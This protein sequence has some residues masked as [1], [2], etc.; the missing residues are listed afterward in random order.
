MDPRDL[1]KPLP[2]ILVILFVAV[3]V[4]DLVQT[5]TENPPPPEVAESVVPRFNPEE[6]IIDFRATDGPAAVQILPIPEFEPERWSVATPR[7]VWAK[8]RT[9]G[10]TIDLAAGGHRSMVLECL[11]GGGKHPVRSVRLKVNQVDCGE[12]ML[13]PGLGSY[14]IVLPEGAFRFGPNR[15]VFS[16][17]DR[18]GSRKNRRALLI[19]RLALFSD[20]DSGV[21][22]L[23]KFR[24]ISLG[25]EAEKIALRVAGTLEV[26][27]NLDD[28]SDALR[29]RY[30]FSSDLGRAEVAV[31]QL[32]S[33][34]V[35]VR[36]A[37]KTT[38]SADRELTGH[39]RISLHGRR[40]PYVLRLRA[41]P[42][43]RGSR[44]V[45]SSLRLTEEGDPTGR[46]W[47]ANPLRN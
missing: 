39:L 7:G 6:P 10:L 4:A 29:M 21:E 8:G 15:V 31:V 2:L 13:N 46:P 24:P 9:A 26:P 23:G 22:N 5:L 20:L 36:D 1:L 27:L 35:G 30:R 40:G 16:F 38:V 47:S 42:G 25:R 18:D 33:G 43:E 17:E 28:R 14:R 12:L 41:T 32:N 3:A 37:V 34:G 45:I 44:L 11:P 19:R